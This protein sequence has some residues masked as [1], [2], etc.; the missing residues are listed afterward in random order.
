MSCCSNDD[1]ASH[2]VSSRCAFWLV[3][4]YVVPL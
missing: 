3:L 4:H 2:A 1:D